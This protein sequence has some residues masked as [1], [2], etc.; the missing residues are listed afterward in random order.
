MDKFDPTINYSKTLFGHILVRID[1]T[2]LDDAEE[3]IV[4]H[5]LRSLLHLRHHGIVDPLARAQKYGHRPILILLTGKVG[6]DKKT[7]AKR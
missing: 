7:I 5:S 4:D 2:Q 6:V 1:P 3:E